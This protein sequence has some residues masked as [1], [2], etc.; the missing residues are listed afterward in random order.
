M[1]RIKFISILLSCFALSLSAQD[2]EISV[3]T[4]GAVGVVDATGVEVIPHKWVEIT[5]WGE[6]FKVSNGK[7]CGLL[8]ASGEEVLPVDYFVIG[9]L[10]SHGKAF[11]CK[12][13]KTA[14]GTDGKSV[15]TGG[16]FGLINQS[17]QIIIPAEHKLLCEFS[18]YGNTVTALNEG[19]FLNL[20]V[21]G[22]SDTLVTDCKYV[23]VGSATYGAG[24]VDGNT[25]AVLV[26]EGKCGFV[27]EP[28]SDMVRFYNLKG[29][30]IQCGYYDITNGNSFVIREFQGELSSLTGWT[31]G[32]FNGI[33]APVNGN[34]AWEFIDRQ[35]NVLRKGYSQLLHSQQAK[36]WFLW[37]ADK[38]TEAYTENNDAI[39]FL[40][41]HKVINTSTDLEDRV[42]YF[43]ETQD[44]V[45]GAY[46]S[47]GNVAI[48]FEYQN[49]NMT[50]HGLIPVCKNGLWGMITE[51]NEPA[52][53]LEFKDIFMP[54]ERNQTNIMVKCADEKLYN[55]H[56][57]SQ[58]LLPDAFSQCTSFL[59]GYAWVVLPNDMAANTY[60]NRVMA[61]TS[62]DDFEQ[63]A[64]MN[65]GYII[66]NENKIVFPVPVTLGFADYAMKAVLKKG[67]PLTVSEA[68]KEV[69]DFTKPLRHY[70]IDEDIE[71]NDWDF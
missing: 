33:M 20:G 22:L 62:Y 39:Q 37:T 56:I 17:A 53:P 4:K 21:Y 9:N 60:L 16:K 64:A 14:S 66:N 24:V 1:N 25:G 5:R 52:V 44:G 40:F 2:L 63:K 57:P 28:Q 10:N 54:M 59:N 31:H 69:L 23:G 47:I 41:G 38:K 18:L 12:G 46:D 42:L 15:I 7:K 32:D 55:F 50:R 30:K 58:T 36:A 51:N 65:F 49:M 61:Q 8:N 6:F 27:A 48:P 68:H 45:F 71:E 34:G 29:N 13:G 70:N 43:V 11:I 3:N 26:P 35:G 67:M 19:R